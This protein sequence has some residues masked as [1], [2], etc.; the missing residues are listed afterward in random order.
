MILLIQMNCDGWWAWP[1]PLIGAFILGAILGWLL[2]KLFGG[3]DTDLQSRCDNLEA[4]LQACR[5]NT[6][7][8]GSSSLAGASVSGSSA[9]SAASFAATTSKVDDSVKDDLTKIEGIGPKI[10]G[11]LNADGIWSWKQ[12][13][14]SVESRVQSILDAAGPAY[15]IHKPKTW[16]EQALMAHKGEWKKLE[17][18]QDELKGGL[19]K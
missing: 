17:K 16:A 12:L 6:K 10:Q 5:N 1:W 3:S 15:T 13:S 4:E 11:L 14:E 18:W 2:S 7:I 19:K 9:S 8:K